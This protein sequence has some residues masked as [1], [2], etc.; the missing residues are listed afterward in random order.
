MLGLNELNDPQ[1]GHSRIRFT[2]A[3]VDEFDLLRDIDL[4][5]SRLFEQAGLFME[6]PH[7]LELAS[8]ERRRWTRCL[9]SRGVLRAHLPS[10]EVAGF[11]ALDTLDGEPYLEQ[12]SVRMHCMRQGVGSALLAAA[13]LMAARAGG[14]HLW[15]TT[16][17]HLSWNRPFYGRSGFRTV[18]TE[19]WGGDI[20]QEIVFQ[21][22]VLPAPEQRVVMRRP[23][24]R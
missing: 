3:A 17:G 21:R 4:D 16:Y 9:R 7:D 24:S 5:A 15:L 19:Q 20:T 2:I 1:N 23:V 6:P 14:Q 18:P 8:A 13:Q 11:M 22:R 10:G 12:L